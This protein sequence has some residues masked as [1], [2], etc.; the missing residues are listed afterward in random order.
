M[1]AVMA[2][3]GIGNLEFEL[4]E[5]WEDRSVVVLALPESKGGQGASIVITRE[6]ADVGLVAF[7]DSQLVELAKKLPKFELLRRDERD[8]RGTVAIDLRFSWLNSNKKMNQRV[9]FAAASGRSVLCIALTAGDTDVT[10]IDRAFEQLVM[11]LKV[12][13]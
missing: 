8:F 3:R 12:T 6:R 4:P 13:G 10:Q 2:V 7:A 9:L 1:D 11:T 5:G